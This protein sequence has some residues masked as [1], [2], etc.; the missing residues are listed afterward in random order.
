M[1]KRKARSARRNLHF[2]KDYQGFGGEWTSKCEK[3]RAPRAVTRIFLKILKVF[4]VKRTPEFEERAEC[5]LLNRFI[6]L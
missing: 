4:S 3:G 6:D 5:L 2:R 1:R